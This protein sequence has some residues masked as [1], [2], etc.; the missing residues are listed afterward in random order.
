MDISLREW[1]IIGGILIVVL[2]LIDGWRRV[3]ANRNRLRLEIDRTLSELGEPESQQ[4]NPELP[5]GGAR[6]RSLEAAQETTEQTAT[7]AKPETTTARNAS[8]PVRREPVFNEPVAQ[9]K[10][11]QQPPAATA[12][13]AELSEMD[14]L[15][16]DIPADTEP[17]RARQVRNRKR[18]MAEDDSTPVPV[19]QTIDEDPELLRAVEQGELQGGSLDCDSEHD[20]G[21][22]RDKNT[23][24]GR[25]ELDFEQPIPILFDKVP[26]PDAADL[27]DDTLAAYKR[28]LDQQAET[29]ARRSVDNDPLQGL[30][31][32]ELPAEP[33]ESLFSSTELGLD[34]EIPDT[35]ADSTAAASEASAPEKPR[36]GLRSAPDPEHV[37]VITVV[38]RNRQLLP[39]PALHKIVTACGMEWGEMSIYHRSE[40]DTPDAAVQFSMAN[41]VAP[42]T[43]DP[44]HLESL[45]TPA[46]SFFMSMS[47]P[48]DPMNAYECMLATAETLAK[49]LD[50]DLLDEDRSVMRPQTKE[51]Y[52][53]RIREFEMHNRTRRVH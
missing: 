29:D 1:L 18:S 25:M 41:A 35:A 43:F 14:P 53:E 28:S 10:N 7:A 3:S 39:G 42:G 33:D 17:A 8:K 21:H 34:E 11:T 49:H 13:Q 40:T 30:T 6:R 46:V 23:L 31:A 5:N 52:R 51:H 22:N 24:D 45:Q 48:D 19:Q 36:P 26:S 37:L 2:I 16:D 4:H 9:P 47:E 32:T 38:G 12:V 50:G 27:P 15:F 20:E 44:A